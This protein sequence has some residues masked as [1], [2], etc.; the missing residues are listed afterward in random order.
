[1]GCDFRVLAVECHTI[2]IRKVPLETMIGRGIRTNLSRNPVIR[3][4]KL[5]TVFN[6]VGVGYI[7]QVA[8]G[9]S[10]SRAACSY[11]P[12]MP[13]HR[14]L[15]DCRWMWKARPARA[16][17]FGMTEWSSWVSERAPA[18]RRRAAEQWCKR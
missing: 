13:Q 10:P 15:A 9:R 1:M 4:D 16:V 11:S 12:V 18:S 3:L 2:L 14:G 6:I 8:T 17:P 7:S 5:I